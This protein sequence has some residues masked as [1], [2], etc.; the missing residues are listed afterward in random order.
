MKLENLRVWAVM[1]DD[2]K[3]AYD[4]LHLQVQNGYISSSNAYWNLF[5]KIEDNGVLASIFIALRS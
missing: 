2:L 1:D 3:M 5:Y 4:R